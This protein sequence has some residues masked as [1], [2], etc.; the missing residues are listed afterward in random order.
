M[1]KMWLSE[2]AQSIDELKA[3][4]RRATISRKFLPILMGSAIKN[5][6]VRSDDPR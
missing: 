4:I 6:Y 2:M 1:L 3:A 5:K